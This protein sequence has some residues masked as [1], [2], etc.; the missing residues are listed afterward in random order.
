MFEWLKKKSNKYMS[1]E[2]QNEI[3]MI[4]ALRVLR[5]IAASL[6]EAQF[7][8]I[9]ADETADVSSNCEQVFGG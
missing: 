4:M 8:T 7:Y 5:Q 9:M 6:H 1:G 3:I 2:I